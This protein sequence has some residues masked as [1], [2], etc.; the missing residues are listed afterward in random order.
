MRAERRARNS[1][2]G[3]MLT[4]EGKFLSVPDDDT[5]VGVRPSGLT[6]EHLREVLRMFIATQPGTYRSGTYRSGT[7][8]V[9]VNR[10]STGALNELNG[11]K[12]T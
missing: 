1:N 7:Y 6:R 9:P 8:P 10:L 11:W 3:V 4:R 5:A 2:V 12:P